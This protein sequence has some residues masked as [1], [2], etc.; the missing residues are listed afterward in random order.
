METPVYNMEGKQT[1]T[2]TLPDSVFGLRWNGPLVKQVVEAGQ[3]NRR[4]NTA[5]TKNRGEVS[6]GGRKPWQQKGT[7]RAR[8]GSTRSPIW[9]G[10][11]VTHG[12]RT[13]RVYDQ[14]VNK[15]MR[16]KALLVSL[17]GKA[18]HNE[19]IVLENF[20][21]SEAR[22]KQAGALFRALS[23]NEH[24]AGIGGKKGTVLVALPTYDEVS[25]RALRNLPQ[26]QSCEV[27]NVS[28]ERVLQVKYVVVPKE[29]VQAFEAV[30]T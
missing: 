17:S 2:M 16:R 23:K 1:G 13:E 29:S 3:A 19:I 28:A 8:H 22:T 30:A 4:A 26:V 24:I 11:G 27:R 5:H 7:G 12:P 9:V 15:Q 18:Q 6:G 21:F 20:A 25:I 14:K 10:G